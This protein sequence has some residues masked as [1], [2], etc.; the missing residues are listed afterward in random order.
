MSVRKDGYVKIIIFFIFTE[1]TAMKIF[2]LIESL[3]NL[4]MIVDIF[5]LSLNVHIYNGRILL[6]DEISMR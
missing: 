3:Y 6:P 1:C 4:N 5:T 2:F